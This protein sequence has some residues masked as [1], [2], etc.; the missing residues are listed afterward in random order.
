MDRIDVMRAFVRVVETGKFSAVGREM[1]I[2]QPAVSKQIAALED[3]V[4]A[5]LIHRTSRSLSM[6]QAGS[7]FYE[8]AL[9]ILEEFDV[10][11]GHAGSRD[12]QLAGLVRATTA[13]A[14][15]RLYIVPRLQELFARHPELS[16]ELVVSDRAVNLVE[17]NVDI[18]IRSGQL[19]DSSLI[20]RPI[21]ATPLVTVASAAY[22]AKRGEPR[23]TSELDAHDCIVFVGHGT[24]RTWR[25]ANGVVRQPKGRFRSNDAEQIREAVLANLGLAQVPGW[26]VARELAS[27]E[28]RAVLAP[29]APAPLSIAAV[30]PGKR[31]LSA[32]VR[33][34]TDFVTEQ[35]AREP[36]LSVAPSGIRRR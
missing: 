20:A 2:G 24:A 8:A 22:L 3:H 7:E 10:A 14:F 11:V 27:G 33:A 21:G 9:R 36:M 29:Y 28:L 6:T 19:A 17:D 30:R 5:Q 31:R 15:G 13:P 35:F 23:D 4:G 25:F 12:K 34:F 1:G 16:I 32:K 18:A 26:L